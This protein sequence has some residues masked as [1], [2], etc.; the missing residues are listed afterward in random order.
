MNAHRQSD[1]PVTETLRDLLAALPLWQENRDRRAFLELALHGHP[2]IGDFEFG[3]RPLTV[4]SELAVKL[5]GKGYAPLPGGEHPV[6]SLIREIRARREDGN[7]E[8]AERIAALARFFGCDVPAHLEIAGSPYPGLMAY[9]WGQ[10]ADLARLFF[11]REPETRELLD[12]LRADNGGGFVLVS[13][14]SGSGKSSL[15]KAGLW[16]ALAEPGDDSEPIPDCHAWVI[17]AMTPTLDDDAFLSLVNSVRPHWRDGRLRPAD[18]ARRLRAD[19]GAF[20]DFL[21]RLLAGRPA[22]LLILDQMEEIFAPEAAAYRDAFAD[23]LR[24]GLEESRFRV[25]ATLRADFQPQLV[26]HP[27]LCSLLKRGRTYPL[28]APGPLALA[29]MIQGPAEAVGLGV[30]PGLTEQLVREADREAGG[31]ALLAA[32]LQD[33]WLAAAGDETL[34]MSHYTEIVGGLEGVL[35]RRGE[36][37]LALLGEDGEPALPRVFGQ[38][39]HLDPETGA[40]TRRRVPLALW[41]EGSA[42]RRLIEVFSRDS[43]RPEDAVRLLVCDARKGTPTVEVAHEALLREWP[44]L[45][46]WIRTQREALI[47]RDEVLRDAARWDARGR[48]DHLLPHPE[49][50]AEVRLRLAAAGLWEDLCR[51]ESVAYFLA[52]DEPADLWDLTLREFRRSGEGGGPAALPLLLCLTAPGR[53][54]ETMRALG[55]WIGGQAPT[56]AA[57]LKAGLAEV[58]HLLGQDEALPWHRRRPAIGDLMAVLGDERPGVGVCP[59]GLPDIDWV[60]IHPPDAEG[61]GTELIGRARL[62]ARYPVTNAQYLAF[63]RADDYGSSDWWRE[64]YQRPEP[65]VSQWDQP[66][67]PRIQV[68]W[69]EA[70]AFCRWLT[71]RYRSAGLISAHESIRLP[72]EAEWELA[73]TGGD[74]REYPWGDGYRVGHANVDE[75]YAKTGPHNLGQTTAVGLY[76]QGISPLGLLDCA[77]NVWDWCLDKYRQP[78]DT[79][80]AGDDDRSVRGGSWDSDPASARAAARV[81]GNP[82]LRDTTVGF[83]LVCACPIDTDH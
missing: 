9:D 17:S 8:V 60:E 56:L 80:T 76:P 2:V 70:L 52:Q 21:D 74:G 40:A 31:L 36:R 44:R 15:V 43:D 30:E 14:A 57:W 75:T 59:D 19:P 46:D 29:R 67:R 73:A 37:G 79:D 53:T 68:A 12:L 81:G 71:V 23:L 47:R 42:E 48:P 33:T 1:L 50:V 24:R 51:E 34:R 66:N 27:A 10:D 32:A 78:G 65:A 64:G 22:W 54:W 16:R 25:I 82:D 13:G 6:C 63:T 26:G 3:G 83:R 55:D 49:L 41:S 61:Q 62:I 5:H 28:G 11:G 39:V 45:A 18:E 20:A 69:V 77:G 72:T 4:A 58:I 38:L 35:T 7:R